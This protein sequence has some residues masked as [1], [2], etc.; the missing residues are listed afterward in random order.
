MVVQYTQGWVVALLLVATRVSPLI[1]FS[2]LLSLSKIPVRIS[3]TLILVLSAGITSIVDTSGTAGVQ[4]ISQ[5]VPLILQEALVGIL[6]AFGVFSA[7]AVFSF[8]GRILDMQMGFSVAATVDPASGAQ[9][10]LIGTAITLA[11]VLTFFLADFHY[12]FIKA[13]IQSFSV[14]PLGSGIGDIDFDAVVTQFG[15]M[16]S[17]GVVVVIPVVVMLLLVDGAL[18]LAARTMP[19]VNMF[20]LSIP[21]KIFVGLI[22]V[23]ILAESFGSI[24]KQVFQSIFSYWGAVL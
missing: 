4:A 16:F 22:L 15:L 8:G 7:F 14:V 3:V 23:A 21:I 13:L 19:Q 20:M 18:A 9:S 24:F 12:V 1:F 6:M 11:A 2:P 10:P 5:L 17:L